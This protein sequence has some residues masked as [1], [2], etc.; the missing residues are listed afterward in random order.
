MSEH[1]TA[2]VSVL[3][4]ELEML[5]MQEKSFVFEGKNMRSSAL[6]LQR[7]PFDRDKGIF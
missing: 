3:V 6:A 7:C 4:R 2:V 1:R 5:Q